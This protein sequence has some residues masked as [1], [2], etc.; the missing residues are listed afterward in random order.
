MW[1]GFD[2]YF[3][4]WTGLTGLPGIYRFGTTTR[5]MTTD[6]VAKP[7]THNPNPRGKY[8]TGL[9]SPPPRELLIP[10]APTA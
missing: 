3:F 2:F 10:A 4:I 1:N 5:A 8:A 9:N 6:I 7:A